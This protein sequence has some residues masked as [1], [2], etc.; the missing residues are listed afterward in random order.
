MYFAKNG[1]KKSLSQRH[2]EDIKDRRLVK[3]KNEE[4][5]TSLHGTSETN[6][7]VPNPSH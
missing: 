3:R 4:M 2:W 7:R 5:L 6:Y 1:E